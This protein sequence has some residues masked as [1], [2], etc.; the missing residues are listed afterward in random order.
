MG[1][2][3]FLVM[4][5]IGSLTTMQSR[6]LLIR[7]LVW[8]PTLSHIAVKSDLVEERMDQEEQSE[9]EGRK[10]GKEEGGTAERNQGWQIKRCIYLARTA[11]MLRASWDAPGVVRI[12]NKALHT[13]SGSAFFA[14]CE[15]KGGEKAQRVSW[16]VGMYVA[17]LPLSIV[18][19]VMRGV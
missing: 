10:R 6:S 17:L 19:V 16:H 1:M 2:P 14:S 9:G 3:T 11:A 7:S 8:S 13:W 18:F 15:Q 5:S 4:C 12:V